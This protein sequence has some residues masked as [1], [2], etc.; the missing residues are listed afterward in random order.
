MT[1]PT[2]AVYSQR[3]VER[4]WARVDR[5]G[6]PAACWPWTG[7]VSAAGYGMVMVLVGDKRLPRRA[8]RIAFELTRGPIGDGLE[9]D[10]LCRTTNCSNP[11][12]T[13]P[14]T[15]SENRRREMADRPRK[16]ECPKGHP[17]AEYGY[18][19][20]GKPIGWIDCRECGRER[21]RAYKQR[22]RERRQ[23]AAA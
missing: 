23:L 9:L 5:S 17:Y 2:P 12:H 8:H 20:P 22:R 13:E 10:H 15:D 21:G 19:A 1:G 11:T 4:F 14:V 16:T 3:F 6:G 7:F 18:Q